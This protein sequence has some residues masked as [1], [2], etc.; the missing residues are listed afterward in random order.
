[1]CCG[2]L[3]EGKTDGDGVVWSGITWDRKAPPR[4][5]LITKFN[6]RDG[7]VNYIEVSWFRRCNMSN[8]REEGAGVSLNLLP[9]L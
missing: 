6:A 7:I 2:G 5:G 1:M 3:T 4:I 9:K 8:I